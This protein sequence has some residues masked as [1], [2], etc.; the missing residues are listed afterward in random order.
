[1]A[2]SALVPSMRGLLCFLPW[3]PVACALYLVDIASGRASGFCDLAKIP[4]TLVLVGIHPSVGGEGVA[5][6]IVRRI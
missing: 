2:P 6:K 3:S 4:I 5:A 1:M